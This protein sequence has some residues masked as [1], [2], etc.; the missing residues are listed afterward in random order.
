MIGDHQPTVLTWRKDEKQLSQEDP[1]FLVLGDGTL[2]IGSVRASDAGIYVCFVGNEMSVDE[3]TVELTVKKQQ[4][5]LQ[6]PNPWQNPSTLIG[7]VAIKV[8][9]LG[10]TFIDTPIGPTRPPIR[11]KNSGR[12]AIPTDEFADYVAAMHDHNNVGFADEFKV[13]Q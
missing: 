11:H 6:K 12:H 7:R 3:Q 1:R 10:D 5:A 13:K 4:D 9:S 8:V 2:L